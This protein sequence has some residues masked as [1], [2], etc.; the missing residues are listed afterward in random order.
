MSQEV[1]R[2]CNSGDQRYLILYLYFYIL[3]FNFYLKKNNMKE[4][5]ERD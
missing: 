4:R 1:I 3:K 5:E 2:D